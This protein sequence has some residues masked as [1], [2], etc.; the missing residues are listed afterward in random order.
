MT[1]VDK[2]IRLVMPE[3]VT[4]V[5]LTS[6]FLPFTICF[7]NTTE[8]K[9]DTSQVNLYTVLNDIATNNVP[10]L[11]S[12]ISTRISKID[13]LGNDVF[14]LFDINK[15]DFF[16]I[17]DNYYTALSTPFAINNFLAY[18][19]SNLNAVLNSIVSLKA[20]VFFINYNSLLDQNGQLTNLSAIV[21]EIFEYAH[22]FGFSH[23]FDAGLY[24]LG[25][26][27][28]EAQIDAAIS[29]NSKNKWMFYVINIESKPISTINIT[30]SAFNVFITQGHVVEYSGTDIQREVEETLNGQS[31]IRAAIIYQKIPASTLYTEF[32]SSG[33]EQ[34]LAYTTVLKGV[35]RTYA[36][37]D[38]IAKI[39]DLNLYK[40]K[41][42]NPLFLRGNLKFLTNKTLLPTNN[43]LANEHVAR[44]AIDVAR[45]VE[46]FL[47]DLIGTNPKNKEIEEKLENVKR[48]V[49]RELLSQSPFREHN[50]EMK[51]NRIEGT[52]LFVDLYYYDYTAIEYI[53]LLTVVSVL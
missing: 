3:K 39:S 18:P 10:N 35:L 32:V 29:M 38:I 44:L 28:V 17:L 15:N 23:Y 4:R 45:L 53:K 14:L 13:V 40:S 46:G 37:L 24:N 27:A 26:Q 20:S 47:K 16:I 31:N 2:E 33:H 49:E 6:I 41:R 5:N 7:Y 21:E 11:P 9:E 12:E 25:M 43:I 52:K 34:R 22:S 36:N 1:F 50:L 19:T 8:K 30:K 48:I 51:I 42:I